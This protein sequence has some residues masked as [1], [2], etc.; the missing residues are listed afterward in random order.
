MNGVEVVRQLLEQSRMM[1]LALLADMKDAPTVSPMPEGGNH[2]LWILGHVMHSE[3]AL[4]SRF[5][6][7]GENPLA[8]WDS[9][10]GRGSEPVADLSVY[11]S[12]DELMVEYERVRAQ[13]L[14]VVDTLDDA[15]LDKPSQAP[16]DSKGIFGTV[17]QCLIMVG[18]HTMFHTGQVADARR[19]AGRRPVMG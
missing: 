15:D 18:L 14:K 16:E 4:V 7:G 8:R 19:S 10:F 2:P 9:L 12:M 11:P 1:A 13:T 3:G 5:I 6:Q 17:G